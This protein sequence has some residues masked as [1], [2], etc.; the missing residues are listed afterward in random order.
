MGSIFSK[1]V[2]MASKLP[3]K[4]Q[5]ALGAVLLHE[6]QSEKRWKKLF[7][8]SQEKLAGLADEALREH[9]AGKT[10]PWK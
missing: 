4:D 1:A 7:E 2:S 6:I 9:G 10:K 8:S 3:K 5:E